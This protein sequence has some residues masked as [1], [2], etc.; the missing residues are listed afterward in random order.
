MQGKI[1]LAQGVPPLS[2]AVARR[3]SFSQ[4]AARPVAFVKG[5][6]CGGPG[7]VSGLRQWLQENP[8]AEVRGILGKT[9]GNGCVNDF[10]RGWAAE[11][12]RAAVQQAPPAVAAAAQLR[13]P[14]AIMSGG[15]EGVI[16]PHF[17]LF[18]ELPPGSA[19][20]PEEPPT[21]ST[22]G[23]RLV[24][25]T[26]VTRNFAPEEVGTVAQALETR[27]AVRKACAAAGLEPS[28]AHFAQVKTPLLTSERVLAAAAE[29]TTKDTYR[30]MALSRAAS[31]LGVAL[32]TGEVDHITQEDIAANYDKFSSIASTSAGVETMRNEVM[33]LG[34]S[35]GPGDLRVESCVMADALDVQ[36]VWRMFHRAGLASE[37]GQ[38]T[39]EARGR[40]VGLLCK[41]DPARTVRGYRTTMLT[42][43][44]F[45]ATRHARA[46]VGGLLAGAVGHARL[47]VSGGAEHQGPDG[48]GPV[49]VIY[50]A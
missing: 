27:D 42:D 2:A 39:P 3:A 33:V 6:G 13:P 41:A 19:G 46:A 15:T 50:R 10:S 17:L 23:D 47:F 48:G 22:A 43:S 8:S 1:G 44:D 49:L 40:V 4:V 7:D 14:V 12:V 5:F 45:Q 24:I 36:A 21:D 16:E 25:G 9:E 18:A 35:A 30:S 34:N 28:V 29:C 37:H 26:A 11:S 20:A 32:A 38:L 31:A